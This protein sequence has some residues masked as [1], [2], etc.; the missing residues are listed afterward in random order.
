MIEV[1]LLQMF[2]AI[3]LFFLINWIGRHSFSVG[4]MQISMFLKVE[5]A[6]AFN[7]LFRVI[8]PI[9]YLFFTSTILYKL[10]LDKY[11]TD[12]YFV[13]IYYV[14]FRLI[15]NLVTNRGLLMNWFRQ[16][17][18][19]LAIISISYFS[20]VEIIYKKENILPDFTT[21]ANELW[22]IILVFMFHVMNQIRVSSDNTIKRKENYLKSRFVFFEKKYGTL[23]NEKV[24]NDKLKAITYALMIYED[25]NRPKAIR[26][27]ENIRFFMT[28]KRHSLGVMQVQSD[29]YINDKESV[30]LAIEKL[31]LAHNK[32]LNKKKISDIHNHHEDNG[33]SYEWSIER[34]I[35]SDYNRDNMYVHEI[36]TLTESIFD[37]FFPKNKTYLTPGYDGKKPKYYYGGEDS[38]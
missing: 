27:L 10:G 5:E 6:P 3:L 29:R 30:E 4:Y 11:V 24:E 7:F 2:L 34:K 31:K 9:V 13:S 26:L 21:I 15:F 37:N 22:I 38:E 14:L 17:I 36:S 33:W 25:F 19:W 18:Y 16:F 35:V 8:S 20:Y 23:I 32:A 1:H 28:K 12:F